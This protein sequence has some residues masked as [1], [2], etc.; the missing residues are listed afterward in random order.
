MRIQVDARMVRAGG[1]GRYIREITG[2]WLDDD[3]VEAI[4]FLGRPEDLEPWFQSL[5]ESSKASI[6]VWKD[7]PYSPVA[8]LRWPRLRQRGGAAPDVSFFPH[9]DVPLLYHPH[10][11]VVTIHDLIHF[12]VP[13]AF[14]W[15][16]RQ[17]GLVLL[18]GALTRASRIL[19]VS[20][21]S[22]GDILGLRPDVMEKIE[23]VPNGVS[24]AF[25]PPTEVERRMAEKRLGHLRPFVLAM[26]NP[27]P[28]KNLQL[29]LEVV[30]RVRGKWPELRLVLVGP[31]EGSMPEWAETVVADRDQDLRDLYALSEAFLFPSLYEGF[32]LPPLE[33]VACGTRVL[34]SDR[35]SVPEVM[36]G[37]GLLLDPLDSSA[38]AE[39]LL[40]LRDGTESLENALG[41]DEAGQR[42]VPSWGEASRLTLAILLAVAGEGEVVA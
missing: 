19:T 39:A 32:G 12:K 27:R 7:T 23:V 35:T 16:K 38:W 8:Q 24:Q 33:A 11:S 22:R 31:G 20:E 5:G 17:A 4:R 25:R 18:K 15:W 34:A 3:R 40:S 42:V 21:Y 37:R 41:G 30:E 10:P 2:P 13:R 6:A 14:P 1:I 36:A 29:V 9:Y 26:G 28:H